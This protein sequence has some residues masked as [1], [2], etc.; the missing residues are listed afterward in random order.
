MPAA[1]TPLDISLEKFN[2]QI[3]ILNRLTKE[4]PTAEVTLLRLQAAVTANEAVQEIN[5]WVQTKNLIE[6]IK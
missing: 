3:K 4:E 5:A 6:E 1:P 2:R